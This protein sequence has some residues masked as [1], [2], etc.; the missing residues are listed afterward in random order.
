ML[1]KLENTRESAL[2]T[3]NFA[4]QATQSSTISPSYTESQI[5]NHISSMVSL[6]NQAQNN[7]DAVKKILIDIQ[8]N[9]D[10][11]IAVASTETTISKKEN[12]LLTAQTNA[13]KSESDLNNMEKNLELLLE[14]QKIQ[15]ISKQNDV[16]T[17][18]KNVEIYKQKL[19]DVQNGSTEQQITI[20]R[21]DV[22]QA[23]LQ[24]ESTKKS[25]DNYR[26]IAP[27]TGTVRKIDFKVGDK[28][29]SN[30][31]KYV[32]IEN[33]NTLQMKALLDQIDIVKVQEWQQVQIIFDAH[34]DTTLTGTVNNIDTIAQTTSSV[35]SF[36]VK[37]A[38]D[39]QDLIIYGWMTAKLYIITEQKSNILTVPTSFINKN[40]TG[41]TI[42]IKN[43]DGTNREQPIE[44]WI[45]DGSRTEIISW[46]Q[47]G[48]TILKQITTT[49][50][51]STSILPMGGWTRPGN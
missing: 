47:E 4:V 23:E 21:N 22:K 17:Q 3:A 13:V 43:T 12:E 1:Q 14:E 9:S 46:V 51:K 49:T 27:F 11:W 24:I 40:T 38:F 37:I 41:Y 31:E 6:R 32:Y 10:L 2:T 29:L 25:L 35:V 44:I 15:R 42:K 7:G 48:E 45:T 28:I 18:R 33:P 34:P 5:N 8:T 30:E 36:E 20:A 19:E 26:I 50:K 16:E 39:P